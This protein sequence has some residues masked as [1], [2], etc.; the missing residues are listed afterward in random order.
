MGAGKCTIAPGSAAARAT[1]ARRIS[2]TSQRQ[3]KSKGPPGP[4]SSSTIRAAMPSVVATA[5][6]GTTARL[7]TTPISESWLKCAAMSGVT[8]ACAPRLT[9]AAPASQGG[10]PRTVRRSVSHGVR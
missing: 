6:S 9:A 2:R 8:A 3:S 10:Q 7:A 4:G 1:S 5:A